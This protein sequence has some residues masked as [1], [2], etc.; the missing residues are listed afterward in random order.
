MFFFVLVMKG[1]LLS[2]KCYIFVE[3]V[4]SATS[5]HSHTHTHTHKKNFFEVRWL[6]IFMLL[7]LIY[8]SIL[9]LVSAPQK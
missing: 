9:R 8:S 1:V 6:Y 2:A 7:F 3:F 5:L 4:I